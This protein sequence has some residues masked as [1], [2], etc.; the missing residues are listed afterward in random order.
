MLCGGSALLLVV[1]VLV[2]V[3]DGVWDCIVGENEDEVAA[4]GASFCVMDVACRTKI[5]ATSCPSNK[6]QILQK[7]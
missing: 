5:S 7:N 3:V 2:V 1:V 4:H 6:I